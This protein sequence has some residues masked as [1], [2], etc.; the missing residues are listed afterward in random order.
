MNAKT[1]SRLA[2]LIF[3]HRGRTTIGPCHERLAGYRRHDIFN[4]R[5]GKLDCLRCC[6]WACLARF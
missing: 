6:R 1:Y 4:P 2:A 5:M 3:C